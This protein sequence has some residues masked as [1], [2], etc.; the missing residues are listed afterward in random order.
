MPGLAALAGAEHVAAGLP[1]QLALPHRAVVVAGPAGGVQ[2]GVDAA[3]TAA[4]AAEAGTS[5]ADAAGGSP[6]RG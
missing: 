5:S 4:A 3:L 2:D 6:G 1:L